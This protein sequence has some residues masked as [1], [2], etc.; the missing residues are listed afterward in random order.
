M[1]YLPK[2]LVTIPLLFILLSPSRVGAQEEPEPTPEVVGGIEENDPAYGEDINETVFVVPGGELPSIS[3]GINTD[4]FKFPDL[5]Q[6]SNTAIKAIPFLLP[7]NLLDQYSPPKNIQLKGKVFHPVCRT[8]K[9]TPN[10]EQA[11]KGISSVT[12]PGW[13]PETLA[14]TKLSQAAGVSEISSWVKFENAPDNVLPEGDSQNYALPDCPDAPGVSDNQVQPETSKGLTTIAFN[15]FEFIRNFFARL[16]GQGENVTIT[17]KPKQFVQGE[18]EFANQTSREMGFLRTFCPDELFPNKVD[19]LVDTSYQGGDGQIDLAFQGLGGAR[20]GYSDCLMASLYPAELQGLALVGPGGNLTYTIP[21]RDKNFVITE[22]VKQR[23]IAKVKASWPNSKIEE[24]WDTVVSRSIA[25]GIN[26]AFTL[27]VWIEES[28]AGG[29]PPNPKGSSQFGCFPGGDTSQVVSFENSLSCF[30]NFTAKDHP[31]NFEEWVRH[32][33]GPN[34]PS[35]CSN[36][37]NFISNL[38]SWWGEVSK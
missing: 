35:I 21:Y 1:R 5:T 15:A 28:G 30:I 36:N 11:S 31:N 18:S 4:E 22:E 10:K 8:S 7:Q 38:K 2:I 19:G 24:L 37:P 25:N 32:F 29:L 16:T 27:A 20:K 3:V 6:L 26:P 23:I 33:C 13:W 34:T 12:T 9:G 17:A 14:A